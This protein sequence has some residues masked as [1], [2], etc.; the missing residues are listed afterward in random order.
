MKLAV[1]AIL[2]AATAAPCSNPT[3]G[4]GWVSLFDGETLKGWRQ[5]N[6]TA[7][8]L[9]DNGTILGTTKK[10][11]P[12]SFLCTKRLYGDFE[13]EFDVKLDA[14]LNSGVQIRSES[15]KEYRDSRVHGYQVEIAANGSAGYIYDEARR[16]W[17]SKNREN[18]GQFKPDDWNHYRIVC[19]GDSLRSWVNGTLCADVTDG[20]TNKGFIGLQVHS[21]GDG[22]PAWVRWR[23]LRIREVSAD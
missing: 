5:V 20:M 11:S 4:G 2:A 3:D 18:K 8:F 13:L 21:F 6:G 14:R 7:T 22:P 19:R 15:Y 10:G 17:L 1:M 16:G 23:N 9:V 12:N